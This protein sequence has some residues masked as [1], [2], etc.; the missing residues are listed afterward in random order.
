[1]RLFL[2]EADVTVDAHLPGREHLAFFTV[3]V[4]RSHAQPPTHDE[5]REDV[6]GF[7]ISS[8][9]PTPWRFE[10]VDVSELDLSDTGGFAGKLEAQGH[11]QAAREVRRLSAQLASKSEPDSRTDG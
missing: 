8:P 10:P 9:V 7:L 1:M 4:V 6:R 5:V 2:I 3:L 11:H